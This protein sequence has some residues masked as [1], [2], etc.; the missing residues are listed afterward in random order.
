LI[1]VQLDIGEVNN[2][3]SLNRLVKDLKKNLEN[4]QQRST[5]KMS[6]LEDAQFIFNHILD[7]FAI[8]T[9]QIEENIFLKK[10]AYDVEDIKFNN[11]N[12]LDIVFDLVEK[13]WP[14]KA[15]LEKAVIDAGLDPI[16]LKYCLEAI[17]EST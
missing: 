4:F 2:V 8:T 10:I 17:D 16:N 11:N 14:P 3:Q 1:R 6:Q 13:V 12:A 15:Q 9:E 7:T 5:I